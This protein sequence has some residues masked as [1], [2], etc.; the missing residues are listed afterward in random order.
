MAV[1]FEDDGNSAQIKIA[2][3][4]LRACRKPTNRHWIYIVGQEVGY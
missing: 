1:E 3:L 2:E 4:Q